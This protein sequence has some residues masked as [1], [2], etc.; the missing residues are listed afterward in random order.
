MSKEKTRKKSIFKII[1]PYVNTKK[2]LIF[3]SF[4]FSSLSAVFNIVPFYYIWQICREVFAS[5]N[6]ISADNIKL[7]AF[8]VVLYSA[9]GILAYFIAL[10]FAHI[11]AYHTETTIKKVGFERVMNMPLGFFNL[12]SSGEIRK[13]INDGAGDVHVFLG[14]QLPDIAGSIVTAI[15]IVV[16]FFYL[17]FRLGIAAFIP[18]ILSFLAMAMM[19]NEE[20]KQFTEKYMLALEDMS[21]ESVEY[22]RSIPVVKTFGQS[23]KSFNRFYK[24]IEDYKDLILKFTKL[25]STPSV[26]YQVLLDST[27]LFLLPI[28]IFLINNSGDIAR[29]ISNF[30][31]YMLLAPQLSTILLKSRMLQIEKTTTE[32]SI[33]RFDNLFDY[34]EMV[35]PDKGVIFEKPIIEFKNVSFSYDGENNVLNNINFSVKQGETLALVG[36]SGSGKTTIARLCA[37][38]WDVNAGEVLIG[39]KNIKDYDKKTLMNNIAFVFQNTELFKTSLREN[40]C[41]GR[42]VAE[43]VIESALCNSM[44]K[45]IIDNLEDGLDTVIGTKGTYLSGGEKQRIALARAFIKNAPIVLLDEATAFA[46]PENEHLIQTALKNLSRDKT[47]IMIAHRMTTVKDADK[48]AVVNK[49]EI[50]EYGNHENLMN[51]NGL[52]KQ[53]WDEYQSAIAWNIKKGA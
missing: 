28:S 9:L 17:D 18:I 1:S 26:L 33:H 30:I 37:R 12:H 2:Y 19:M 34:N 10:M 7:Y 29:I 44:S 46:D 20:G 43:K 11:V 40:I 27:I 13:I 32:L 39:G 47:T 41:F 38:F 14:H 24:A 22:V 25:W 23:V 8:M 51:K 48:I 49:G 4:F 50:V 36:A 35:Y 42:E 21:S 16:T 45:E 31:L 5:G 53:M 6:N 52:Y 15:M 3:L